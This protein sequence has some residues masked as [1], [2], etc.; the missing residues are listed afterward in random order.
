MVIADIGTVVET[1]EDLQQ[2]GQKKQDPDLLQTEHSSCYLVGWRLM[3]RTENRKVS[4]VAKW[5]CNYVRLWS[6]FDSTYATILLLLL[7]LCC[8]HCRTFRH[9]TNRLTNDR[10]RKA[11]QTARQFFWETYLTCYCLICLRSSGLFFCRFRTFYLCYRTS[12]GVLRK[13]N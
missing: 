10:G 2:H 9:H 13:K 1:Q 7:L 4:D 11:P 6:Q 5:W 12:Y 8:C 3:K